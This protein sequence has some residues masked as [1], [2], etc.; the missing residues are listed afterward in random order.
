[1]CLSHNNANVSTAV[2]E[3]RRTYGDQ[4]RTWKVQTLIS[5][6]G[7]DLWVDDLEASNP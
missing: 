5:M 2:N 7:T 4:G 6:P 1:M 3:Q